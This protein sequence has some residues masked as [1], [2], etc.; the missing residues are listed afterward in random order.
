MNILLCGTYTRQNRALD[1]YNASLEQ[2]A[3]PFA[4]RWS[5]FDKQDVF[6]EDFALNMSREIGWTFGTFYRLGDRNY[7]GFHLDADI[8][9]RRHGVSGAAKLM[10]VHPEGLQGFLDGA[11]GEPLPQH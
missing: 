4:Y 6:P 10:W 2:A 11:A 1:A 3:D 5:I 7:A 8:L 9:S